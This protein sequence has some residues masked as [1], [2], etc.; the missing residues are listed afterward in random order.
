MPRRSVL[1]NIS[2]V[3]SG[4]AI[5]LLCS[6]V[7]HGYLAR[8]LGPGDYGIL[9]FAVSVVSYFGILSA[10]GADLWGA[11][12]I[13]RR[14]FGTKL[15]VEDIVSL[16]LSLSVVSFTL[17]I[18]LISTW[19]EPQTVNS[20]VL[21]QAAGLFIS[22]ITLDFAFQGLERLDVYARRQMISAVAALMGIV[23][24]I[25]FS[26]S[27]VTAAI[28]FQIAAFSAAIY[29]V[30]IFQKSVGPLQITINLTAWKNILKASVPFAITGVVNAIYFSIDVIIIGLIL[31]KEDV[32]HYVAAGRL[33]TIGLSFAGIFTTAFMPILSRLITEGNARREASQHLSRSVLFL[34][35]MLACGGFV[36]A[37]DIIQL[38]YGDNFV[39]AELSLRL[40][41]INLAAAQVLV[42]YNLQLMVWNEERAQMYIMTAGAL[43]NVILNLLFIPRFGIEAAATTTLVTTLF[44]I[45]LAYRVQRRQGNECHASAIIQN[46]VL[47]AIFA[48]IGFELRVRFG[49]VF[50]V[51]V[52]RILIFGIPLV[53]SYVAIGWGLGIIRPF[54]IWEYLIRDQN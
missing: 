48:W 21:I 8:M 35:C 1:Q 22:A 51:S 10:L 18:I 3:F 28:V 9:G 41:M 16:R 54:K 27:V 38:L 19:Q 49:I 42:V 32:G 45:I 53:L 20:V 39:D 44:V 43:L 46:A 30:M 23:I 17:M 6:L 26:M 12:T 34:G 7:T 31:S 15:L 40:L 2:Y 24:F 5:V 33:L 52:G 37:P 50:E 11:R 47:F 25:Q 36:L 13:A 14:E 4:Q 29:T